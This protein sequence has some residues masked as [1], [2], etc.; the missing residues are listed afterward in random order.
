MKPA[1]VDLERLPQE[2][3]V[4]VVIRNAT[5]T[6]LLRSDKSL[7]ELVTIYGVLH[8]VKV[9]RAS[10]LTWLVGAARATHNMP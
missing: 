10:T 8:L 4:A 7:S 1:Q 9:E 5:I 2:N 6:L 3:P